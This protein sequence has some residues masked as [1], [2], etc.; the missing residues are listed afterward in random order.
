M[1][2]VL[3]ALGAK[4]GRNAYSSGI[5][6]DPQFVQVGDDSIIGNSAM[7]IPHVI[8]GKT[9]LSSVLIGKRD[10]RLRAI[11]MADVTI[12]DDATVAIQSVVRKGT[13][14]GAGEIWLVR[15]PNASGFGG[16]QLSDASG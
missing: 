1:R 9:R 8:E 13:R 6:M 2:L 12:E 7:I 3:Q 15:P 10:D 11:I 14:I 4:F 5:V 16:H